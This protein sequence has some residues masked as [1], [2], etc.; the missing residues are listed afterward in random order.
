MQILHFHIPCVDRLVDERRVGTFAVGI[1]VHDSV[2]MHQLAVLLEPFDNRLVRLLALQTCEV[3]DLGGEFAFHV[4]RIHQIHAF[5][6]GDTI[7]VLAVGWSDVDG[8]SA[9]IGGHI[10]VGNDAE[11]IGLVL[12]IRE[13]GFVGDSN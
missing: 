7:V 1:T 12:E 5:A 4:E 11:G 3:R 10:V 2:L 13:D 6:L 8:A 9:V